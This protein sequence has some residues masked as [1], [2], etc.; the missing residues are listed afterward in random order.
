ME[1]VNPLISVIIPVYNIEAYIADCVESIMN[2]TYQNLQIIL[3]DDGSDDGSGAICNQYA[4]L[5]Q[6]IEVIHQPNKGLVSARKNGLK[7]AKGDYIGFV[8]GDDYIETEMYERLLE[9]MQKSNADFIHSGLIKNGFHIKGKRSI[10][11]KQKKK[12]GL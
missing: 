4:D 7:R 1:Q 5:D 3:V 6:R 10:S 8:D 11:P 2:Q 12:K 9:E